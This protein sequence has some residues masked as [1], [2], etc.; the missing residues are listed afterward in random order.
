MI[1]PAWISDFK[2]LSHVKEKVPGKHKFLTKSDCE[3]DHGWIWVFEFFFVFAWDWEAGKRRFQS[4]E[5]IQMRQTCCSLQM[6]TKVTY[7]PT[8]RRSQAPEIAAWKGTQSWSHQLVF[9]GS[10][11]SLCWGGLQESGC[12]A[13]GLNGQR[14]IF[15][16]GL[17]V[18]WSKPK[19]SWN[20][21]QLHAAQMNAM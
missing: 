21:C 17:E 8:P 7:L 18:Q 4:H 5:R 3:A 13:Y 11:S 1:F 10:P 20:V 2:D 19:C 6:F 12:I 15:F 9:S 14:S 16:N